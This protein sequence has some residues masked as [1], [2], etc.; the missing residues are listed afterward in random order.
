MLQFTIE[1]KYCKCT[2]VIEGQNVFEAFKN[3][4]INLSIWIV[5]DVEKVF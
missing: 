5:T 2:R 4:G 1:H 3:N